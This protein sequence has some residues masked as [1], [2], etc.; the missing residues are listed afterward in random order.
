MRLAVEDKRLSRLDDPAGEAF[1]VLERPEFVA[2]LVGEV[3]DAGVRVVQRDVRDVGVEHGADLLADHVKEAGQV[4][5]A[6]QLL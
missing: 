5:L 1:A 6:G 2:V 4:E 3:D